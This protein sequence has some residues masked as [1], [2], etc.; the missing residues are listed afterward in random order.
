MNPTITT[1][2]VHRIYT[3]KN[4]NKHSDIHVRVDYK[5]ITEWG[6]I[7]GGSYPIRSEYHDAN[8]TPISASITMNERC[9]KCNEVMTS[10]DV[11]GI[12]NEERNCD[13]KCLHAFGPLC[14]CGCGGENHGYAWLLGN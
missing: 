12:T 11:V 2:E 8:D 7:N 10:S 3:C 1:N 14:V 4:R 13:S 6:T 9:V 5:V